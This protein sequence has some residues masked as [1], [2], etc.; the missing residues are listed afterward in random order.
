[1]I[2][3]ILWL[4]ECFLAVVARVLLGPTIAHDRYQFDLV[5]S[6]WGDE[7]LRVARWSDVDQD[8]MGASTSFQDPKVRPAIYIS[9]RH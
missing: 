4:A 2:I 1:M 9:T 8:R 7:L 6:L 5:T 3:H